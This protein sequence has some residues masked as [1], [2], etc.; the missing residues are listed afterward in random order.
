MLV[1][2]SRRYGAD[3]WR[4]MIRSLIL[5]LA[6]GPYLYYGTKDN[7]FHFRGRRVTL[8]EHLLHLAIGVAI[9]GAIVSAYRG[10]AG[11]MIG[12]LL[13]FLVVGAT[14]EYVYHRGLPEHETDL[15]AK[16]HMSLL[17]F[18]IVSVATQW[19]AGQPWAGSLGLS[20]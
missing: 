13:L 1:L 4:M 14:D 7:L 9:V 5:T 2:P 11:A 15:H 18:V 6:L 20:R 16:G 19:L 10:R 3:E 8:V 17:M 12:G